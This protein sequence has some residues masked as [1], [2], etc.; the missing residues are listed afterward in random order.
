MDDCKVITDQKLRDAVVNNR[1]NRFSMAVSGKN[2]LLTFDLA[3]PVSAVISLAGVEYSANQP[4]DHTV[5]KY[6]PTYL[7]VEIPYIGDIPKITVPAGSTFEKVTANRVTDPESGI[8][9]LQFKLYFK[10]GKAFSGVSTYLDDKGRLIVSVRNKMNIQKADNPFGYRL[11]GVRI[12]ITPGHGGGDIG[13]SGFGGINEVDLN[14]AVADLVGKYLSSIGADVVQLPRD[15]TD[16][17]EGLHLKMENARKIHPDILLCPHHNSSASSSNSG[18][19]TYYYAPFTQPMAYCINS[20][21][22]AAYPD[23]YGYTSSSFNRGAKYSPKYMCRDMRF[24]AVLIEYGF[25]NNPKEFAVLS[26]KENQD[27][28]AKATVQGIIDYILG[29]Q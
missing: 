10:K 8:R 15:I 22:A 3:H 21:I 19:E 27:I 11:D 23:M 17:K 5:R 9:K 12:G 16:R 7:L 6:D 29:Q 2:T 4:M 18:T 13:A 14:F 28:L 20:R 1:L 25:V 26:K 24:P